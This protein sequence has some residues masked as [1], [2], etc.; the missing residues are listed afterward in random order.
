MIRRWAVLLLLALV[1]ACGAGVSVAAPETV[2]VQR[3]SVVRTATATGALSG[4]N[5]NGPGT[6]AVIPFDESGAAGMQAGQPVRMTFEAI[7]GLTLR[8][9]VLAVA[10]NAVTIS[11]VTSY[12]VTIV[13]EETD[14][15]LRAGQSAEASVVTARVDNVLM[16]PNKAV[17]RDGAQAYVMVPGPDGKP[18]RVGFGAGV[19]GDETTQVISGLSEGREVLLQE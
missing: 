17:T 6:T 16:V 10:P 8:G 12:Y 5:S 2:V 9:R 4:V 7:P 18:L 3:G 11:G 13:L 19:V 1:T 14:P 15:R